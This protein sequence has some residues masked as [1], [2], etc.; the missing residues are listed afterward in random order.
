LFG[1]DTKTKTKRE[2][3]K[4][5]Y[6]RIAEWNKTDASLLLN[7][8]SVEKFYEGLGYIERLA[9]AAEITEENWNYILNASFDTP[10]GREVVG[11]FI[12]NKEENN[13][14]FN[15]ADILNTILAKEKKSRPVF[16]RSGRSSLIDNLTVE[17][18]DD[19]IKITSD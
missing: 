2:C 10:E 19:K 3:F 18:Q 15:I 13:K 4:E 8:A 9:I 5:L 14:D 17:I 1:I 12:Y 11:N 16:A 7:N 6:E